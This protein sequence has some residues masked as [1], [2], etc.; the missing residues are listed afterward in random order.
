MWGIGTLDDPLG[1]MNLHDYP[2]ANK[3]TA[4]VAT[5]EAALEIVDF[6]PSAM[7]SEE[8][9]ALGEGINLKLQIKLN[10]EKDPSQC[11]NHESA[12]EKA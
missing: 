11:L 1:K 6:V 8:E 4:P 3:D 10:L 2:N 12:H 5:G 7:V 9:V